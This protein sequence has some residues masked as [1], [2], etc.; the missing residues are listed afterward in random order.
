MGTFWGFLLTRS[1]D[2]KTQ[3]LPT[4]LEE[5]MLMGMTEVSWRQEKKEHHFNRLMA[6]GS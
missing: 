2:S 4:C 3:L 1:F 5:S 6:A